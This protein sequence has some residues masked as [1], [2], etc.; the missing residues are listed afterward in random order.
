LQIAT[1]EAAGDKLGYTV[2]GVGDV[3]G[4][5]FDDVV[6]GA[7]TNDDGGKSAGSVYLFLGNASMQTSGATAIQLTGVTESRYA[8]D[9]LAAAGD[10]DDDGYDDFI[11]GTYS[12][13]VYLVLGKKSPSDTT[14]TPSS[15]IRKFSGA[16]DALGHTV[17]GRFFVGNPSN[18]NK[19]IDG[20][21]I[22]ILDKSFLPTVNLKDSSQS[23]IK[24]LE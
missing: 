22:W 7:T 17:G 6:V 5:G 8:G 10:V 18:D 23:Y 19:T 1:G 24:T 21:K 16:S 9:S 13:D 20:G 12:G 2:A 11:I 14:L 3:N 15:S 4:D